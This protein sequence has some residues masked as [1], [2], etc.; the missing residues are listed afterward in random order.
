[1]YEERVTL[2]GRVA[3]MTAR[4]QPTAVGQLPGLSQ[5]ARALWESCPRWRI[6]FGPG[7][8]LVSMQAV[9]TRM[10]SGFMRCGVGEGAVRDSRALKKIVLT[11]LSP[12]GVYNFRPQADQ[13]LV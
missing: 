1:M 9:N 2:P 8:Q 12:V 6:S 10:R 7:A 13:M 3:S 5:A 11:L 4:M